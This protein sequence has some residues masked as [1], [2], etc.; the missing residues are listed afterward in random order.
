[1][2][3]VYVAMLA[4]A[5][6]VLSVSVVVEEKVQRRVPGVWGLWELW[7]LVAVGANM[8]LATGIASLNVRPLQRLRQSRT[9]RAMAPAR[10]SG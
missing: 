3:R 8:D 10:G 5:C 6:D 1:M 4:E 2:A 9:S 7:E